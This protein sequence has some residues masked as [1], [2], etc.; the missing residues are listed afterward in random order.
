M[1]GEVDSTGLAK[2]RRGGGARTRARVAQPTADGG[3]LRDRSGHWG[4]GADQRRAVGAGRGTSGCRQ[5]RESAIRPA[6]PYLGTQPQHGVLM[7][8][9]FDTLFAQSKIGAGLFRVPLRIEK[10]AV[11]ATGKILCDGTL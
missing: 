3:Y 11:R 1:A 4:A 5:W 2:A 10:C 8:D 6:L 9:D 7:G